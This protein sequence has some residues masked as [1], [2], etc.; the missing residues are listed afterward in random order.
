[1]LEQWQLD[2]VVKLSRQQPGLVNQ[3]FDELFQKHSDLWRAVV[4]GAYLDHEI[5]LG[6]AAE[7]LG[8]PRAQLQ[9]EFITNGIPLRQGPEDIDEARSE[10]KSIESWRS[11]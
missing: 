2:Q 6:K 11:S 1:M 8:L 10:Y 3:A 9:R 5:N 4:I 7:L